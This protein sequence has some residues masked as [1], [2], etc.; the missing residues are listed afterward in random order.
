MTNILDID[1]EKL[2]FKLRSE[3]EYH[4]LSS[5]M[6]F[7]W[8][9]VFLFPVPFILL[10]IFLI[11]IWLPVIFLAMVILPLY[12]IF[13]FV[14]WIYYTEIWINFKSRELIIKKILFKKTHSTQLITNKLEPE[15]FI[16]SEIKRGGSC[17]FLL[18][19]QTQ[20]RH[21][22]FLFKNISEKQFFETTILQNTDQ[23]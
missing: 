1:S 11:R 18:S 6:T 13:R 2:S 16:F 5:R 15:R 22:L 8:K 7:Y 20:T 19:Y 9:E 17:K 14:T 4:I 12:A 10:M 3:N 21:D 23:I